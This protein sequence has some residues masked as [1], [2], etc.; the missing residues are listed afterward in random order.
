MLRATLAGIGA[1]S[2]IGSVLTAMA[3]ELEFQRVLVSPPGP[4]RYEP[5]GLASY[6][7]G[8]F[9]AARL[10][11][12][13]ALVSLV[14]FVAFAFGYRLLFWL[15]R[16]VGGPDLDFF[17]GPAWAF[18]GVVVGAAL[19]LVLLWDPTP[20]PMLRAAGAYAAG[21]LVWSVI[22]EIVYA[23][24]WTEGLRPAWMDWLDLSGAVWNAGLGLIIGLAY[25]AR[26]T[27]MEIATVAVGAAAVSAVIV[28][29][30]GA[31]A[32]SDGPTWFL[33]AASGVIGG[34]G[35]ALGAVWARLRGQPSSLEL[36][37]S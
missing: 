25:G 37:A 26:L 22:F 31:M 9:V 8:A 1:A 19:A 27:F 4:P 28:A 10:G 14:L 30:Q 16:G 29:H 18:G 23:A 6:A 34:I 17:A 33:A 7:T 12:W 3:L 2:I 21:R 5:I 32:W 24:A 11:G 36:A 13:P 20:G 35:I 15:F